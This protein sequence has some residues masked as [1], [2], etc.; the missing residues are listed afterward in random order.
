[1][2]TTEPDPDVA[3]TTDEMSL[4]AEELD[5][6]AFEDIDDIEDVEDVDLDDDDVPAASDDLDDG[7]F[8]EDAPASDEE[9]GD[10]D[11]FDDGDAVAVTDAAMLATFDADDAEAIV[12]LVEDDDEDDEGDG[13]REGEFVCRSCF[14]AMRMSALADPDAMLCRDCA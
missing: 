1:M 14:M 7:A 8:A 11:A 2:A 5:G 10:G 12:A 9:L 13:V 3:E 4:D 6:D